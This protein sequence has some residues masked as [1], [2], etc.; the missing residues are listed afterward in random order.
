MKSSLEQIAVASIDS[1]YAFESST[2]RCGSGSLCQSS[3][4]A[5]CE[6]HTLI[7]FDAVNTCLKHAQVNCNIISLCLAHTSIPCSLT[8]CFL[9]L[10]IQRRHSRS[11]YILHT[12]PNLFPKAS[13]P[14]VTR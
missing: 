2:A 8:P 14:L 10:E 3:P 11:P 6:T 7:R 1:V 9:Y 13:A 4:L 5:G 12:P